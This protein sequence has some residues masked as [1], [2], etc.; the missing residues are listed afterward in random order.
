MHLFFLSFFFFVFTF[1]FHG[2][3]KFNGKFGYG[4]V[5]AEELKHILSEVNLH[6]LASIDNSTTSKTVAGGSVANTI[7]GLAT[8]FGINCGIIGACGDD[9]QG[10][11]FMSNM[12]FHKVDISRLRLKNGPT[13]QVSVLPPLQSH[14]F[15]VDD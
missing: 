10:S 1:N 2:K 14:F 13:A 3:G 4:K 15:E 12:S 11:L 6:I 9:E 7:R 5:A 8:G